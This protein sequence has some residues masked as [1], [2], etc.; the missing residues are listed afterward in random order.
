MSGSS[1]D[2]SDGYGLVSSFVL[3]NS[4]TFTDMGSNKDVLWP[5]TGVDNQDTNVDIVFV[6]GLGGKR[7]NT[8]TKEKCLWPQKILSKDFPR[9]RIMT[10][11][12]L[13][14]SILCRHSAT[15]VNIQSL[16]GAQNFTIKHTA[17]S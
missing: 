5:P 9:A 11:S 10:V 8:W 1:K 16:N 12:R 17:S 2:Q 7:Y 13:G 4:S 14:R 15:T 6:H 3:F